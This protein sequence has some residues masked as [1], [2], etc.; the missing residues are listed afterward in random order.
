LGK[1]AIR[2]KYLRSCPYDAVNNILE[3]HACLLIPALVSFHDI[4][5]DAFP[6]LRRL[7]P[8]QNPVV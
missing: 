4:P 3:Q 7:D 8:A 5:Q 6:L 1:N 2:M